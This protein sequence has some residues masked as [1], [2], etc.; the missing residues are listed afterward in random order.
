MKTLYTAHAT[1][2]AGRD[3]VA[4][5]NDGN[6]SVKLAPPGSNKPNATNPEQLFACG[7]GACFGGAVMHVA[8]TQNVAIGEVKVQADVNLNQND[9][10]FFISVVLNVMIAGV[11][12]A[13]AEKLVHEAHNNVCPYS[14]ATR[15]NV[16]V[17]LKVNNEPLRSAA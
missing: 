14:K 15:G 1:A 4:E 10:G 16:D 8:K 5:T 11:D 12:N 7:Y 2:I 13:T 9:S 17:Q 6:L 3:G